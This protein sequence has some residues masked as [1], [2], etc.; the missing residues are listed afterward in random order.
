MNVLSWPK[1][2]RTGFDR[3]EEAARRVDRASEVSERVKAILMA[4]NRHE[5][6]KR[7]D[8]SVA[9]VDSMML[10]SSCP[11]NGEGL[12]PKIGRGGIK[13]PS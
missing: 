12:Q 3:D 9:R 6:E 5:D 11:K 4:T 1:V 7:R 2:L 13:S 10:S 8:E